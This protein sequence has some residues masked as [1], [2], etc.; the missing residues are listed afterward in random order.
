MTSTNGRITSFPEVRAW[1][2]GTLNVLER[3]GHPCVLSRGLGPADGSK[4]DH[5]KVQNHQD[6]IRVA[7]DVLV[8]G[9]RWICP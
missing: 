2:T 4:D 8:F 7:R 1:K 6:C 5:L 9:T 3:F